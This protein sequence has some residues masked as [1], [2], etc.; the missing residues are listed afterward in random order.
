MPK[1]IDF[2]VGRQYKKTMDTLFIEWLKAKIDNL[3]FFIEQ[4]RGKPYR[5][6]D[7]VADL[8]KLEGELLA[9]K[10]VLEHYEN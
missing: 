4:E 10:N 6:D 2:R 1:K 9:Y 3:E 8:S 5:D 7:D